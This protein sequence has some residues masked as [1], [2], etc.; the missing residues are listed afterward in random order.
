MIQ[1]APFFI[2]GS[3]KHVRD[4]LASIVSLTSIFSFFQC[5]SDRLN[6]F[7]KKAC[8]LFRFSPQSLRTILSYQC[9]HLTVAYNHIFGL[10]D[11]EFAFMEKYSINNEK[12]NILLGWVQSGVVAML[13]LQR[14]IILFY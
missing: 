12:V 3:T 11:A 7:K 4:I 5:I 13:I 8:L 1:F 14:V 2:W 9:H 10:N 6:V